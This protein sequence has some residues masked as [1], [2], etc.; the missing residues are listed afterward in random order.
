MSTTA[1]LSRLATDINFPNAECIPELRFSA[2]LGEE[3]EI[4]LAWVI[5][6]ISPES[7]LRFSV[8]LRDAA[9]EVSFVRA[10]LG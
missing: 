7:R 6:P 8:L 3:P 10:N 2:T 9:P 5:V 1:R 4:E